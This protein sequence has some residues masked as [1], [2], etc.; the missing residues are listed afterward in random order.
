[1]P[2]HQDGLQ[3]K[4]FDRAGFIRGIGKTVE[5]LAQNG[6][7]K[8]L[9][10]LRKPDAL[11]GHG[12]FDDGETVRRRVWGRDLDRIGCRNRDQA[13][14][15]AVADRS[16]EMFDRL[17]GETRARCIVNER[18]IVVA[19]AF[20][21]RHAQACTNRMGARCTAQPHDAEPFGDSERW[22]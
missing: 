17:C 11:A 10:G 13:T 8:E 6:Q 15:I 12:P 4:A 3:P 1:M 21:M 22:G 18:P 2:F 9:R 14:H 7:T 16:V 5:R 19:K 20:G